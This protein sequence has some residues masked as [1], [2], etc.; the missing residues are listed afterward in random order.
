MYE[1]FLPKAFEAIKAADETLL[2]YYKRDVR[3]RLKPDQSPVSVADEETERKIRE[4][5]SN[6]FPNH[7]FI[8]EEEG[9]TNPDSEFKWII[10]PLDAT[11]NYL[12]QIPLFGS[13]LALTHKDQIVLG[14]S[15]VPLMHEVS[16]AVKGQGAFINNE[17]VYVSKTEHLKDA[18]ISF[19]GLNLKQ[20]RVYGGC[21]GNMSR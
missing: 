14:V 16:H 4:V 6:A 19:E 10:D 21:L 2:Y 3:A 20:R 12:R 9:E 1:E 5:I 11:K 7:G 8:G 18:W 13:L 17:Q 15:S